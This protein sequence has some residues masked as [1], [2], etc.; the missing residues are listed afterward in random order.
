[1]RF[2]ASLLTQRL[3][4]HT[5]RHVA[6]A[7][8]AT[9]VRG[10]RFRLVDADAEGFPGH[11]EITLTFEPL[12]QVPSGKEHAAGLGLR[13]ICGLTLPAVVRATHGCRIGTAPE[14]DYTIGLG[15]GVPMHAY[16]IMRDRKKIGP[17]QMTSD[18]DA[19]TWWVHVCPMT[20]ILRG[21]DVMLPP[22]GSTESAASAVA[23]TFSELSREVVTLA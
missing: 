12:D 7:V 10:L 21:D 11:E 18:E 13:S 17:L 6:R 4:W 19:R 23:A 2:P 9:G 16:V 5:N 3:Q 22:F 8:D 20:M 15:D 14:F 1:M